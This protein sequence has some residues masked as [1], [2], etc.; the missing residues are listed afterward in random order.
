MKITAQIAR[1]KNSSL[2]HAVWLIWSPVFNLSV[3]AEFI[4]SPNLINILMTTN[5]IAWKGI[6][7][8][9]LIN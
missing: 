1:I 9:N 5:R 8:D 4:S 3:V 7:N 6:N 2:R